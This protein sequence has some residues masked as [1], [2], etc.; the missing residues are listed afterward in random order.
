MIHLYDDGGR[1]WVM[2]A[3]WE[4]EREGVALPREIFEAWSE[5]G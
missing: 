4:D 5:V 2:H 3:I 1:W